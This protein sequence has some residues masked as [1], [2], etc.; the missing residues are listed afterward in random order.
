MFVTWHCNIPQGGRGRGRGGGKEGSQ[1]GDGERG[2]DEMGER[3][4]LERRGCGVGNREREVRQ[5]EEEND[6]SK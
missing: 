5:E 1:E 3:K 2:R 4:V 6:G